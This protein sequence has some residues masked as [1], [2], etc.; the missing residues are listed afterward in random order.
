MKNTKSV[1]YKM[2]LIQERIRI[3]EETNRTINKRRKTKK[4]RI[5]Q[6]GIFSIQNANTLLNVREMDI[7]LEEEMYMNGRGRSG[8]RTIM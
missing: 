6:G 5:Q 8:G 1:I 3:F 4:I 7:Q 2:V